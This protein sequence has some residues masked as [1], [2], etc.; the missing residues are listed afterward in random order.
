MAKD[1][2]IQF[3]G[4]T[5][6]IIQTQLRSAD[7]PALHAALAELTGNAPDF[8]DNDLAVLDFSQASDLP[9]RVAFEVSPE[10]VRSGERFTVRVLFA[11]EGQAAITLSGMQLTT[12]INGRK[13]GGP[14]PPRALE[15]G[16]GQRAVVHELQ[17]LWREDYTSWSLEVALGTTRGERYA[18]RVS[19][20]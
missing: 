15:V 10:A 4:T 1:S 18:N 17:D 12:T 20:R 3:K 11:N 6:K 2:P 9:G 14:V 19:S 8:F 16:P 7:L 5:L 13:T